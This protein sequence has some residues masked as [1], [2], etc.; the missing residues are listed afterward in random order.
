MMIQS[1]FL[2]S[3]SGEVIIEKHWRQVTPRAVCEFFWNEANKYDNKI[4]MP[5]VIVTSQ[6]YLISVYRDDIFLLATTTRESS[7]LLIIEFLHR[8]VELFESYFSSLDEDTIKDNFSI[9]YQLLEEMV[10]YGFALITEP[11][12]L[13]TMIPPPSLVS[14]ITQAVTFNTSGGAHISDTLPDSILSNMP[15]RKS[16]IHYSQ[17]EI[18]LDLVEEVDAIIDKNGF[19]VASEVAGS[20][21]ANSKLSGIPDLLLT[22]ANPY[23]LDDCSFHPCVRYNRYEKDQVVS[24]VPPDGQFELMRYRLRGPGKVAIPLYCQPVII[25]ESSGSN[26]TAGTSQASINV[27]VG[28]RSQNT[29]IFPQ[30][31]SSSPLVVEEVSVEIPFTKAVRTA[32]LSATVGSVLFDE[33]TKVATWTI[34]KLTSANAPQLTGTVLL[35]PTALSG[36]DSTVISFNESTIAP[37]ISLHWVV[38]LASV[39][40]LSIGSLQLQ[41][42]KYKPYKG[43]RSI[44][45]S[46]RIQVRTI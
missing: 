8:I 22:F 44:A 41:G 30:G 32:N 1:F 15:W 5:P 26:A 29:L 7:P 17:N 39:S 33:T 11:N 2:L 34:G 10:D 19:L 12:L 42:E 25:L 9:I 13:K 43:M 20:V 45:K 46:G 31:S 18:Y 23:L 16:D 27:I 6:Y 35:S 37:S 40:G 38:P 24:F 14:Q 36:G 4:D 28:V 21:Q 3:N